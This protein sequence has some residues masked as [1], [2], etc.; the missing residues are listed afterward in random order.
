MVALFGSFIPGTI[1][2]VSQSEGLIWRLS[3]GVLGVLGIAAVA[4]FIARA[5]FARPTAGQRVLLVLAILAVGAHLLA[6]G[7][8]LTQAELTFV[9]GLILALVVA[10]YNFLLLLFSFGRAA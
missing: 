4:A 7:G 10:A 1:G 9:L 5:R 6:A 3:N 8:V 2:L